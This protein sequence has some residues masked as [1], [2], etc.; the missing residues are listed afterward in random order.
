MNANIEEIMA[1]MNAGK[2]DTP[3][4]EATPANALVPVK[5]DVP[6][7]FSKFLL[8]EDIVCHFR[9]YYVLNLSSFSCIL[10]ICLVGRVANP[11][12]FRTPCR[13]DRRT[14]GTC[15]SKDD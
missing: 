15:E 8:H 4:V 7:T 6:R 10:N 12:C 3:A 5:P 14:N 13:L 1:K 2:E 11:P 9:S